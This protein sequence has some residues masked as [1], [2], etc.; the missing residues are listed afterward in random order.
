M[1]FMTDSF[2]DFLNYLKLNIKGEKQIVSGEVLALAY[3]GQVEGFFVDS[4]NPDDKALLI[5]Q[6]SHQ[7]IKNHGIF[8]LLKLLDSEGIDAIILKGLSV[9]RFYPDYK[10]RRSADTDILVEKEH[11]P[12]IASLLKERGYTVY[13]MRKEDH[14]MNVFNPLVGGIEFHYRLYDEIF[15]DLWFDN[16]DFIK[17][18]TQDF[19]VDD[20]TFKTLGITDGFIFL[21]LHFIKHY[22]LEFVKFKWILDILFYV[23]ANKDSIEWDRVYSLTDKLGYTTLLNA[24]LGVGVHYLDFDKI[25]YEKFDSEPQKTDV[26]ISDIEFCSYKE[27]QEKLSGFFHA[28]NVEA[29]KKQD[30]KK[31]ITKYNK[32]DKFHIIFAGREY[33]Q[34]QYKF[35][36]KYPF[37][38]PL[39]WIYRVFNALKNLL[40]G[41]RKMTDFGSVIPQEN[42]ELAKRMSVMKELDIIK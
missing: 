27:N 29:N 39:V 7:I 6:Y 34:K 5:N 22:I 42:E 36:V 25:A 35:L 20:L 40:L 33:L 14:H 12:K 9:S 18:A 38:L 17:E 28:L 41:K 10:L 31:Y 16:A 13:K 24:L 21:I 32:L 2:K 15:D 8:E 3:A 37:F 4:F 26:L 23:S 11:L 30:Y 1:K 19:S